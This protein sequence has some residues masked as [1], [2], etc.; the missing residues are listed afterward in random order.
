M[1]RFFVIFVLALSVGLAGSQSARAQDEQQPVVRG[2]LFWL[3]TCPHCHYVIDEVL[4]PLQAQY[5]EQLDIVLI[6]VDTQQAAER[7]QSA[8]AA[9]GKSPD[10]LG[11]PFMIVGDHVLIGSQEIPDQLPGLIDSYL[12]AGGVDIPAVPGLSDLARPVAPPADAPAVAEVSATEAVTQTQ[13]GGIS[14]G[15]PA[16][17]VLAG[18]V[19]ALVFVGV[20]LLLV[21]GGSISPPAAGW[22]TWAIPALV[23]L[24]MGVAAYLTYVE[25]QAAAAVCGPVGDCNAV[26]S[27]PYARLFGVPVGVIGLV[28]YAAIFGAWLWGRS[29]NAAARALLVGMAA[30][31]V[32]FSIYLTYLELFVIRAV[33]MWCLSSAVIITLIL[34]AGAAW[35]AQMWGVNLQAEEVQSR[36]AR[37]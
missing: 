29:G 12:A 4:P 23:V 34:L 14:G 10:Q 7:F 20:M 27:S 5:G 37:A 36:P 22:S 2:V 35:L 31:G 13:V 24:G 33:C 25:T 1:K 26:Q 17:L 9:Y 11:V 18:M 3:D 19:I 28:G 21:R 6:E 16:F 15:I 32:L 8:G 30:A